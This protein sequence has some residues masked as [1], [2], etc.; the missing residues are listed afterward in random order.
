MVQLDGSPIYIAGNEGL[1]PLDVIISLLGYLE[2][3]KT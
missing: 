3:Q 2:S 1:N